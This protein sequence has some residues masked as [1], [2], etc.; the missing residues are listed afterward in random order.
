M[1]CAIMQP[2]Y[3]PWIGYFDLIDS[4]DKFVFLDDVKLEKCSWQV[5]NRIKTSQGELYLTVPIKSTKSRLELMINE[6]EINDNI[7]WRKKHLKSIFFAYKKTKYFEEVYPFLE[8]L[9]DNNIILIKDFN[10]NIIK[11]IAYKI[12][13][14]TEFEISSK[15]EVSGKKDYRLIS[16]CKELGCDE[17]IS[18][19]GSAVYL[20]KTKPC[21]AFDNSKISLYYFNYKHPI[22]N[23]LYGDFLPFMSI[24]DL[25]FN[26]GFKNALDIIRSGREDPI[27]C[28]IFRERYL[29][30]LTVDNLRK[31]S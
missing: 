19:Q 27:D 20:E 25:L 3:I 4:V 2:T 14:E 17:Y 1:K 18:P 10:I 24:V 6:A 12:G 11:S 30:R 26:E 8:K 5:R 28:I 22:Y 13:I 29:K 23:Q 21:G 16:I 31:N 7:P 9:I 15:L